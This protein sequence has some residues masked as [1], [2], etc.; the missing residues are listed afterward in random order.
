[1]STE[2]W[3][4]KSLLI[5]EKPLPILKINVAT[6]NPFETTEA[7]AD[8]QKTIAV[9]P[10]ITTEPVAA[11]SVVSAPK[12]TPIGVR[13][14]SI[15]ISKPKQVEVIKTD[16]EQKEIIEQIS[17]TNA[18]SDEDFI[19]AW[20]AFINTLPIEK[21]VGFTNLDLPVRKTDSNF[22]VLVNNV[23]QDN[24]INRLLTDAVQFIRKQLSNANIS[25][26]TKIAE[27][28]EIQRSLT[29]EQR[30]NEMVAK[31]PQLEQFRK[32]LSLEID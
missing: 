27:E 2:W 24:E 9:T 21:R 30:Y 29:P 16:S 15:S 31:N 1:M 28:S 7:K 17:T 12:P 26:A 18:F 4:K 10:S 3:K 22:E 19:K 11:A 8:L 14:Q 23:M 20:S 5:D 6:D 32:M 25:I 13:P